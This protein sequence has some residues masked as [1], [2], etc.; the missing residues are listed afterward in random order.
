VPVLGGPLDE[1]IDLGA[2][3]KSHLPPGAEGEEL[4]QKCLGE[5]IAILGDEIP[6]LAESG[7]RGSILED[8]TGIDGKT[9]PVANEIVS[10][11]PDLRFLSFSEAAEAIPPATDGVETFESETGRIDHFVA[12]L[13]ALRIAMLVEDLAKG[14]G[15][16]DIR[17]DPR[18]AGGRG[19]GVLPED[20]FVDPD[21]S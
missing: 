10:R 18:N 4:G 8:S 20:S 1:A 14:F 9:D 15:T 19:S 21:S 6:I 17:F 3:G 2:I 5:L 11:S 12:G 7:E 16:P 13:A